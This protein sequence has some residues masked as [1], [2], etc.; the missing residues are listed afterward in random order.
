[1]SDVID[2]ANELAD[3]HLEAALENQRLKSRQLQYVGRCH[4]CDNPLEEGLFCPGGECA[5][6]HARRER[7]GR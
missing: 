1:M 4:N 7:M 6:D 5:D 3:L 2:R